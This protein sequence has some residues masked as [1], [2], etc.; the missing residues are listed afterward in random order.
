MLESLFPVRAQEENMGVRGKL[1]AGAFLV[2][3]FG[4]LS[5]F[6]LANGAVLQVFVLTIAGFVGMAVVAKVN[7]CGVTMLV[8]LVVGLTFIGFV[9]WE[10][11]FVLPE[12]ADKERITT[13]VNQ[14][15][16]MFGA[17]IFGFSMGALVWKV[18]PNEPYE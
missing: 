7:R 18:R 3:V 15:F 6:G 8:P 11:Y 17:L 13:S 1:I 10:M 14:L 9:V 4:G 5:L 16:G 2:L 12:N